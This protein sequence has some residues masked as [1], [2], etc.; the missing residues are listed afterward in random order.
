[1]YPDTTALFSV[2]NATDQTMTVGSAVSLGTIAHQYGAFFEGIDTGTNE[3]VLSRLAEGYICVFADISVVAS[4]A[5]SVSFALYQEDVDSTQDTPTII[6]R[7]T[8][9]THGDAGAW[10]S[11]RLMA[12]VKIDKSHFGLS[13]VPTAGAGTIKGV[14]VLAIKIDCAYGQNVSLIKV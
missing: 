7:T 2:Q 14:N 3:I 8:A 4:S 10:C 5:G 13:I 9:S 11:V 6:S 12:A 1:M